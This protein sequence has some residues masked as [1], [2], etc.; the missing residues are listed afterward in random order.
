[1]SSSWEDTTTTTTTITI[2]R[3]RIVFNKQQ[4]TRENTLQRAITYKRIP[5][6]DDLIFPKM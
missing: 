3:T 1:M 2:T 6:L 4:E 5:K